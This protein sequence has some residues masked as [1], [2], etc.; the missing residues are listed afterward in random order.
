MSSVQIVKLISKA[1]FKNDILNKNIL[2]VGCGAGKMALAA[3]LLRAENVV[4]VDIDE[5]AI[6]IA[7]NNAKLLKLNNV[8]F[9][10]ND[11]SDFQ[12]DLL[13]LRRKRYDKFRNKKLIALGLLEERNSFDEYS[14]EDEN[15]FDDATISDELNSLESFDHV[16]FD[17]TESLNTYSFDMQS[18]DISS[19]SDDSDGTHSFG[20][21]SSDEEDN[22]KKPIL[23]FNTAIM[24]PP[25]A[26]E[27]QNPNFTNY[28]KKADCRMIGTALGI[29]DH[30][31]YAYIHPN[32][33]DKLSG[34]L[35]KKGFEFK[36]SKEIST[37]EHIEFSFITKNDNDNL[38]KISLQVPLI[39][40]RIEKKHFKKSQHKEGVDPMDLVPFQ[41]MSIP[42]KKYD[43]DLIKEEAENNIAYLEQLNKPKKSLTNISNIKSKIPLNTNS[44]QPN[45]DETQDT[46]EKPNEEIP[47]ATQA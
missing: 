46:T 35:H 15:S 30:C 28:V 19:I 12:S 44:D 37:P 31:V 29:V 36:M 21:S 39:I 14:S 32:R 16:S 10:H 40:V 17:E 1:N 47:I 2:N 20:F 43:L 18:D 25:V 13:T 34:Y 41:K 9:I 4:G 23:D 38:E 11:I 42:W 45:P 8:E 7:N 27:I 6:K 33:Y 5:D 22:V 24:F 26:D 3:R